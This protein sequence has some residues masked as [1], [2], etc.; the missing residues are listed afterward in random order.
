[1][2]SV[3]SP[4]LRPRMREEAPSKAPLQ[5]VLL[6]A[7]IVSAYF[8]TGRIGL[9]LS[10]IAGSVTLIWAPT[11][12]SLAALILGGL[13]LW[14]GVWL[15]AF[16]VNSTVGVPW[17]AALGIACGNTLEAV[18]GAVLLTRW[19]GLSHRLESW[20]DLLGFL[21]LGVLASP[22]VA[23]TVG[24]FSL[25]AAG[26][27]PSSALASAWAIWWLGDA[28]GALVITPALLTW[29]GFR[30][31]DLRRRPWLESVLLSG[32][33]VLAC[34]AAWTPISG[35]LYPSMAFVPLP[36]VI[37]AAVR[38]GSRGASAATLG[39]VV[40]AVGLTASEVG[41]FAFGGPHTSMVLLWIFISFTAVTALLIANL[42]AADRAAKDLR[43]D[44]LALEAQRHQLA[45]EAAERIAVAKSEFLANM[46]HEIRTPMV[47]II[48]LSELL[49]AEEWPDR[50]RHRL[51]TLADSANHLS[52]LIDDVLDFSKIDA[53]KML[54]EETDFALRPRMATL[55]DLFR[56]KADA[57]GIELELQ[58][59]SDVP[60]FIRGDSVRLLQILTNGVGNAVKFT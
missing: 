6:V 3:D 59:A 31:R 29:S 41:P 45:K 5:V 44:Q 21:A 15:G 39:V 23:A 42:A 4:E 14:P 16:L 11:G 46:S 12:I 51:E 1:M 49:L 26:V 36:F 28:G 8:V 47:G 43:N 18:V 25:Y 55:I 9:D 40:M 54:L 2:N 19:W 10:Q 33:M 13:R 30:L 24:S 38:F 20:R 56:P 57:K 35:V 34:A 32:G 22:V 60:E 7:I 53:G 27:V 48:G 50:Q 58:V 17:P 52:R 37:W